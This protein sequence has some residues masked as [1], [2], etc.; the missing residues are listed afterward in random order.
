[1]FNLFLKKETESKLISVV[2]YSNNYIFKTFF[3]IETGLWKLTDIITISKKDISGSEIT[4]LILKHLSC[5]KN[6][7]EKNV[8]FKRMY[9]NY[10]E[11]TGL[12]SIKKQINNSK[13]VQIY[14]QKDTITF[15]PTKNGGTKGDNRGYKELSHKNI[16]VENNTENL[17][18]YLFQ[19]LE[20]CE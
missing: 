1:M 9:E 19:C 18:Q 8:D 16:I 10:K 20:N 3:K 14:Q 13:C 12:S 7:K 5:S 15:T 6:V 17:Y 4:E 11:I 2:E